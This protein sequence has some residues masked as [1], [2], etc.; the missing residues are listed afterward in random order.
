LEGNIVKIELKIDERGKYMSDDNT[1]IAC[2]NDKAI[3]RVPL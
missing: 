2:R 3:N 1:N